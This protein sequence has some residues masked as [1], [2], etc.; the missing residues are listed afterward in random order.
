MTTER[1]SIFGVDGDFDVSGFAPQKPRSD[2]PR[3]R[4]RQVSEASEFRSREPDRAPPLA[5]VEQRRYRTGRNIH[6]N[7]KVRAETRTRFY[8][9]ADDKGWVL[10]ETLERAVEALEREIG[11]KNN[12]LQLP[13]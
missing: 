5:D 2:A 4:I 13:E 12:S 7:I 10:G 11:S 1:A 6:L 3:E 8:R 9:I